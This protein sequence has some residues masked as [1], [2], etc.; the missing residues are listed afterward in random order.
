MDLS[1]TKRDETRQFK[2]TETGKKP[3]FNT[4]SAKPAVFQFCGEMYYILTGR[5]INGRGL[6]NV[7]CF[8]VN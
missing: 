5:S 3:K 8:V 4:I 6:P 1:K 7:L 2:K